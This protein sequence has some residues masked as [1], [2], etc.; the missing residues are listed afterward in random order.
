MLKRGKQK[1]SKEEK[2]EKPK[3]KNPT[4]KNNDLRKSDL[5]EQIKQS[6]KGL[7][8]VSET[9]AEIVFFSGKQAEVVDQTS[10]LSRTGNTTDAPVEER[11]FAD[12]F[13]RL[14]EIQDWFGNE[15]NE[16]AKKFVQLK[17]LL[18]KNLRD[19]K[20]FKIGKIQLDIYVIGLDAEN[21]LLGIQTQA[22]ET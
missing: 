6:V 22:V 17:E 8:Y 5:P 11:D 21:N 14:T 1:K 7:S 9:D 16:T 18:E 10:I 4:E 13:A 12:F 2:L 15:E 19:L 3:E 20:V